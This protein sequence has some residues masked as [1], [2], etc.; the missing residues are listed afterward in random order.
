MIYYSM[1][2]FLLVGLGYIILAPVQHLLLLIMLTL[3]A[4]FAWPKETLRISALCCL[5]LIIYKFIPVSE[6]FLILVSHPVMLLVI[7]CA[8]ARLI[9]KN[10]IHLVISSSLV[11]KFKPENEF[12]LALLML[13]VSGFLSMWISNTSVVA[14][15][16]P[17]VMSLSESLKLA[18]AR[19]L[20]SIAYGA[21]IGGMLTPIGTPA[22]LVAVAY[23]QRYFGLEIDFMMW[24]SYALPF[25]LLLFSFISAY[26]WYVCERRAFAAVNLYYKMCEQQKKLLA[27]LCL[28]VVLWATQAAPLGGWSGLLGYSIKEEWVGIGILAI[29]SCINFKGKKSFTLKD[30][31]HLPISS[32]AM[33][34]AGIFIAEAM[35]QK[36]VIPLMMSYA[37]Q[38]QWLYNYQT[39]ALF[40]LMMSSITELCSNTAVTS[41]GLPLSEVMMKLSHLEVLPC[42]FLITFSANSAFMLPTATPPNAL[43]LGTGK[44]S[45]RELVSV[46]AIMSVASLV[47]LIVIL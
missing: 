34:V 15:L 19:L 5:L 16:I 8:L 27:L 35:V 7:G 38:G 11:T 13:G 24:F 32:I 37:I 3:F 44:L 39:L 47:I 1:L 31:G 18:S 30:I 14:M 41:L 10:E 12:S 21:T 45:A 33:V 25:V 28:C 6:G 40:G 29:C 9:V 2:G 17:V 43:V 42:I 23:A 22:N 46:G 26:F 20:I 4:W 36:E